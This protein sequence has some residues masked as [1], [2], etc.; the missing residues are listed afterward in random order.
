MTDTSTR[1]RALHTLASLHR[2]FH[3]SQARALG[4]DSRSLAR[5]EAQGTIEKIGRGLYTATMTDDL[6]LAEIATRAPLATICLTSALS[7]HELIDDIPTGYDL[8]LPRG[9]YRPHLDTP[10]TWHSF[11]ADTFDIGRDQIPVPG[12]DLHASIYSPARSIIDAFRLR[13]F[14]GYETGI[15]ALREWLSH[16]GNHPADILRLAEQLPRATGPLRNALAYLS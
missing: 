16:R 1:E 10:H 7:Y 15:K 14:E 8:A 6:E 9:A 3:T 5:L 2:P 13:R 12:T 4:L 11:D